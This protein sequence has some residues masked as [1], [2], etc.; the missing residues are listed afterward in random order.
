MDSLMLA[1]A[2]RKLLS[3]GTKSAGTTEAVIVVPFRRVVV[4]AIE[5]LE[6]VSIVVVPRTATQNRHL[7]MAVPL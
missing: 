1:P 2:V 5:T 3:S 4:V 7:F 6:V